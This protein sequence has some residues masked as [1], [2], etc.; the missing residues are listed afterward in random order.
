MSF[1]V[2]Q[3]LVI[4]DILHKNENRSIRN[5]LQISTRKKKQEENKK[6]RPTKSSVYLFQSG[7]RAHPDM[8]EEKLKSAYQNV[9][10]PRQALSAPREGPSSA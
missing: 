8:R 10:F 5:L 1:C 3:T 2:N 6:K 9:P 7:L 4:R